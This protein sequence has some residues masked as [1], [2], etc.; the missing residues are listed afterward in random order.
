[1]NTHFLTEKQHNFLSWLARNYEWLKTKG[2]SHNWQPLQHNLHRIMVSGG[3]SDDDK[4]HIDNTIKFI[5]RLG[6]TTYNK[7]WTWDK[8]GAELDWI[9]NLR[10]DAFVF[11][12]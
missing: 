6:L 4:K 12:R 3:Y 1:M 10:N 11:N 7:D 9:V 2:Y 8:N 5:K